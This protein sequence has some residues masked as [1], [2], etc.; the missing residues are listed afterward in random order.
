MMGRACNP[1]RP[2]MCCPR[3][4]KLETMLSHSRRYELGKAWRRALVV[5]L[6]IAL[7]TQGHAA[8]AQTLDMQLSAH[9][10]TFALTDPNSSSDIP[11]QENPVSAFVSYTGPGVLHIYMLANSDMT[12]ADAGPSIPAASVYWTA[13]GS[14]YESGK[15]SA[16]EAVE[17]ASGPLSSKP[18]TGWQFFLKHGRRDSGTYQLSV[19][20]VATVQ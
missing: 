17:A 3:R 1:F 11:A 5:C 6:G 8:P 13:S 4:P 2:I 15:M 9:S 20:V 12:Q 10:L 7:Q 18:G 19:T 16:V 14:G